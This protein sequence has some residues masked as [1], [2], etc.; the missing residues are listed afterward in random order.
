M[1]FGCFI[2]AQ[3]GLELSKE[4][5][6]NTDSYLA[7]ASQAMHSLYF[8]FHFSINITKKLQKKKATLEDFTHAKIVFGVKRMFTQ[9]QEHS[10]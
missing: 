2:V 1:W 4:A 5:I 10:L 8:N 3:D 7:S 9:R 6:F